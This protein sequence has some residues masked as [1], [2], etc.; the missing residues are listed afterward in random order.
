M[1]VTPFGCRCSVTSSQIW[2]FNP[3]HSAQTMATAG[4]LTASTVTRFDVPNHALNLPHVIEFT[5]ADQFSL[6]LDGATVF[7]GRVGEQATGPEGTYRLFVQTKSGPV[8]RFI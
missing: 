8:G 5:D 1:V 4:P 2:A 6:V 7:E 3:G